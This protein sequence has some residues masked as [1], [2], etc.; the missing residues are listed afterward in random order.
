METK[1]DDILEDYTINAPEHTVRRIACEVINDVI[2]ADLNAESVRYQ[3]GSLWVDTDPTVRSQ[4]HLKKE[5]IRSTLAKKVENRNIK[6]I[7]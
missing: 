1:I 7:H 5:V 4:I 3:Q 2:G 6:D